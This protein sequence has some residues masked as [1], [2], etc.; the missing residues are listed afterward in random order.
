MDHKRQKFSW[1]LLARHLYARQLAYEPQKGSLA[2]SSLAVRKGRKKTT[3]FLDRSSTSSNMQ[4]VAFAVPL[5]K[6]KQC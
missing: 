1:S 5:C 6:E 4:D 2:Y 3:N